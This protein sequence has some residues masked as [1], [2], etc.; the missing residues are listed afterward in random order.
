MTY[1][2]TAT[3]YNKVLSDF[4][5]SD[6]NGGIN[7]AEKEARK[8]IRRLSYISRDFDPNIKITI[9]ISSWAR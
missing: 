5:C 1:R 6:F 2:I 8:E 4:Y 9:T 7:K 3:A